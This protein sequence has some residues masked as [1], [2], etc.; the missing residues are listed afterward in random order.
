VL[1]TQVRIGP[2]LIVSITGPS[3]AA[4]GGT[5]TLADTTRNQGSAPAEARLRGSICPPTRN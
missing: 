3:T 1:A 2:D 4:A 5:V